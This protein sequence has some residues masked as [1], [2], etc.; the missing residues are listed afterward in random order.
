MF[1]SSPI[2]LWSPATKVRGVRPYTTGFTGFLADPSS[3]QLSPR[4]YRVLC[5]SAELVEWRSN[6][7]NESSMVV[8]RLYRREA[9]Q[10]G[11]NCARKNES[12][13]PVQSGTMTPDSFYARMLA[14]TQL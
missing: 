6:T 14:P 12:A 10:L 1:E 2:R 4:P 5:V 13:D 11:E 3:S 7:S 8:A 9:N